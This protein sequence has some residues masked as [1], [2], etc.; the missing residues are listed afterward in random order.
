MD[1]LFLAI[2]IKEIPFSTLIAT[3]IA[4]GV[5]FIF[6]MF[7][8]MF[9]DIK[10]TK[11]I[12]KEVKEFNK[13]MM[14]AKKS[15]NDAKLEKLKK[16]QKQ[17]NSLQM[18]LMKDNFKS[19]IYL[20]PFMIIYFFLNTYFGEV[21]VAVSPIIIPLPIFGPIGPELPFI[22]WYILSSFAFSSMITKALGVG[23][24]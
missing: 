24:S 10:R 5:S 4:V 17:M 19:M 12:T 3:T 15:G 6:A 18:S 13:S 16:K 11:R 20:A 1:Y 14:E 21:I 9:T 2:P 23:M 8:R 22:T 7:R